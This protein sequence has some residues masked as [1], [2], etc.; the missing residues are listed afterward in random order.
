MLGPWQAGLFEES[1]VDAEKDA[2]FV[3]LVEWYA[4]DHAQ[5]KLWDQGT[6][7]GFMR[8]LFES[9]TLLATSLINR[10]WPPRSLTSCSKR[11]ECCVAGKLVRFM[12]AD[13]TQWTQWTQSPT[14]LKRNTA[15]CTYAQFKRWCMREL[16]SVTK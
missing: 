7:E 16:Y 8:F 12:A 4:Q 15:A 13:A 11:L 14:L 1:P 3:A 6:V 5:T 9:R 2:Y 10:G